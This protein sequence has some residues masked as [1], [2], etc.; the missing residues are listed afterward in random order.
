MGWCS[1]TDIMDAAVEAADKLVQGTYDALGVDPD[2][3]TVADIQPQLDE[4]MRPYVRTI[5]RKLHEGDWDCVDEANAFDRFPQE[6][7]D[8][9]DREHEEWL[10]Q[11]L[12]DAVD[13]GDADD[14]NK[15]AG[16][17]AAHNVKMKAGKD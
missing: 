7:Y 4:L 1:A 16:L 6:M 5:A 11:H 2:R 10:R 3:V 13:Y 8:H 12:K 17:L 15:W 14:V 9:D